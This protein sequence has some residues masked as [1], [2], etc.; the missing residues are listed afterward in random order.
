MLHFFTHQKS[1]E[2]NHIKLKE[3]ATLIIYQKE[4][5]IV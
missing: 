4:D 2:Q 5:I 3:K 1:K